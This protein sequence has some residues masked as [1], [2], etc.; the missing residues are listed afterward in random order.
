MRVW[1]PRISLVRFSTSTSVISE[2]IGV[3]LLMGNYTIKGSTHN[4]LRIFPFKDNWQDARL[5]DGLDTSSRVCEFVQLEALYP[6]GD[7]YVCIPQINGK[8]IHLRPSQ[9]LRWEPWQGREEWFKIEIDIRLTPYP[10]HFDYR[11]IGSIPG[12]VRLSSEYL[13]TKCVSLQNSIQIENEFSNI[14]YSVLS[15]EIMRTA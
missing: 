5:W 11:W 15:I 3:K 1:F 4:I 14:I 9:K 7:T 8:R 2:P 12:A 13:K 6:V 10:W